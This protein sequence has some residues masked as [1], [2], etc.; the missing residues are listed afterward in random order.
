[1]MNRAAAIF[2]AYFVLTAPGGAAEFSA[3][4][5]GD[6]R[7]VLPPTTSSYLDGGLGKLRYGRGDSRPGIK[8][9]EF[10]GEGTLVFGD[11][12][13]LQA[14]GR[15]NP[16]YGPAVDLLEGFARFAPKSDSAW[17]WSAR[18]GAFFPTLSLENEQIGWSS[19]WT[20][21]PSA[22]NSWV[23]G[24]LRTIGAEGTVQWRRNGQT[25]TAI[26]ALFADNDPAGILISD[27]GW[28]FDDRVAGL[29]E[30]T[31]LPDS[32]GAILHQ[33]VPLE[34]HLFQEIDGTPGWYLDLSWE[35]VGG[36]GLE[37][38][39][40]DNDADPTRRSG[41]QSAW[42]TDF[43]DIGFRQQI[44]PVT[45]LSQAMSG[46]T[47]IRPSPASFTRTDF[48]SAYALVGWDLDD[49]WMAAR[50]DIFQTRTGTAALL[51]SPLSEDGHAFDL[52]V[53]WLPRKWLRLSAEYLL[54]DDTRAQ[55]LIDGEA[56]HQTESQFQLV[57]R[58]YL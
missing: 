27:R 50:V 14:D 58:T 52:T 12:W 25:V 54:V 24:E 47:V 5:F 33:P 32:M 21:T 9:G 4:G 36:T 46:S 53:S 34:R 29:F 55:R 20:I 10:V 42:H 37:L 30:K 48:K 40:Y 26:G 39:R 28:N 23:G 8:L 57:A 56:P 2:I 41:G 51:P 19:F 11:S 49:W 44:G 17:S 16:E 15:I 1:M 7:L 18:A 22:I 6:V 13:V 45:F 38:M 3:S 35:S 31:R 43:W